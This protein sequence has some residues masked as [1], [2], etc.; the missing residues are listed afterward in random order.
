MFLQSIQ[1]YSLLHTISDVSCAVHCQWIAERA[2]PT[3]LWQ[4]LLP[5]L[6][7]TDCGSSSR[8]V[9]ATLAS[10]PSKQQWCF[11]GRQ[12]Q[13]R[14]QNQS[15]CTAVQARGIKCQSK[16]Y[17]LMNKCIPSVFKVS[18]F[19]Y[20]SLFNLCK[21]DFIFFLTCTFYFSVNISSCISSNINN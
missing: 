15:W 13:G 2:G 10:S 12:W 11:I 18:I 21:V 5:T 19:S 16:F 6:R 17:I 9:F 1:K 8:W 3:I 20:S 7:A 14:F 4:P